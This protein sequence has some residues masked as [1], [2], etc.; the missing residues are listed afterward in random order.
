MDNVIIF[1]CGNDLFIF[2]YS[3]DLDIGVLYVLILLMYYLIF[4]LGYFFFVILMLDF[5]INF[6]LFVIWLKV[7]MEIICLSKFC[8]DLYNLV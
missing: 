7:I 5:F 6:E 4:W 8:I 3:E 1:V 2:K